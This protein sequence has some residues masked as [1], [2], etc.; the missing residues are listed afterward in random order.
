[1]AGSFV[2]FTSHPSVVRVLQFCHGDVQVPIR[3]ALLLQLPLALSK[4]SL[5]SSP[6]DAQFAVVPS[7]V[8]QPATAVQSA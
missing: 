7:V 2:G 1:L 4:A 6:H 3:Q 8:S 5:Q